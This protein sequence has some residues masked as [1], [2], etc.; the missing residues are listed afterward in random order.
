MREEHGA[1]PGDMQGEEDEV[2]EQDMDK[3]LEEAEVANEV[4][5]ECEADADFK[6]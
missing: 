2:L 3:V 5:E 1:L 4:V 6:N